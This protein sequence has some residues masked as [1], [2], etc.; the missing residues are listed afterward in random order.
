M[1]WPC[2]KRG[3]PRCS[4]D[5]RQTHTPAGPG[6]RLTEG[7]LTCPL[8]ASGAREAKPDPRDPALTRP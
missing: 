6:P 2:A 8:R 3:N 5:A 4:S 7:A 1:T